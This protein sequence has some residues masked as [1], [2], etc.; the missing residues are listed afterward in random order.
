MR[1]RF[2][3]CSFVWFGMQATQNEVPDLQPTHYELLNVSNTAT[4]IEIRKAYHMRAK[5]IH[6]DKSLDENTTHLFQELGNAYTTLKNPVS[7]AAYDA[8]LQNENPEI[9]LAVDYTRYTCINLAWLEQWAK[10]FFAPCLKDLQ[11]P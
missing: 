9:D 10:L 6:P 1:N 8:T 7:R 5:E 2:L 4:S 11:T 3:F